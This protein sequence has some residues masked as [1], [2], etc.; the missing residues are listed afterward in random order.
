VGITFSIPGTN[1]Y[2]PLIRKETE[3]KNNTEI[4]KNNKDLQIIKKEVIENEK[5]K[6]IGYELKH[7]YKLLKQYDLNCKLKNKI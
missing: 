7:H 4:I 5:I 2:L 3:V 6:K 1:Y